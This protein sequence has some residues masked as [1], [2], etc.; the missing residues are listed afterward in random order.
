MARTKIYPQIYVFSQDWIPGMVCVGYTTQ[1]D[2]ND[3][4]KQEVANK[5]MPAGYSKPYNLEYHCDAYDDNG[6]IFM[7]H[8]VHEYL[9][10][11]GIYRELDYDGKKTEWFRATVEEVKSAIVAVKTGKTVSSKTTQSFAMRPEQQAAVKMASEYFRNSDATTPH[12][13]FNAKMRFGKCFTTYQL[14]K[15]MGWT[16][17]LVLT[18]KPAVL[19]SW[20]EDLESHVDFVGWQFVSRDGKSFEDCDITKPIVAF[21][22]LQDFN[23]TTDD[24]DIKEH[25]K[26]AYNVDWDCIVFDEYHYGAWRKKTKELVDDVDEITDEFDES[27]TALKTKYFLYLSGTPFRALASNEFSAEQIYNWTYSDEQKAKLEF[28]NL[29]AFPDYVSKPGEKNPYAIMPQMI[30]MTYQLPEDIAQVAMKTGYDEF[31][32]NEFFKASF[33][34]IDEVDEDGNTITKHVAKFKY[35]SEVS[36]FLKFITADD[37]KQGYVEKKIAGKDAPLMPYEDKKKIEMTI[38]GKKEE[39]VISEGTQHTI[40][41]LPDVA[42]CYAMFDMLKKEPYFDSYKK[43]LC[44]GPACGNGAEAKIP[45]DNA[46]TRNPI[47]TKTITL[48]C[49]KLMTGVT[50]KPWSSIF[51]LQSCQSPETYFQSAFRVQSPWTIHDDADTYNLKDYCFIFDFAPN[52][53]LSQIAKYCDKQNIHNTKTPEEAVNDFIKFLPVLAY[54]GIVMEQVDAA[55]LL[56][57]AM[58]NT[59]ATLLAKGWNSA[60]LVNLD[61]DVLEGVLKDDKALEIIGS[62]ENWRNPTDNIS[63]IV[64]VTKE[65]G[66]LKTKERKEGLSEE[67]KKKK[68]VLEKKKKEVDENKKKMREKLQAFATRIPLFIYLADDRR[69]ATLQ[70]IIY[71]LEPELFKK[72]TG[73]SHEDFEYLKDM[74]VI[75]ASLMNKAVYDF[76]KYEQDS[77]SY[78]G[79]EKHLGE[80]VGGYDTIVSE[81]EFKEL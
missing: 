70:N 6:Q 76:R 79:I 31:D 67:E 50:I 62:I 53:A 64:N 5:L 77:L 81:S 69:A 71:P 80:D 11:N 13:L 54:G 61:V 68:T 17:I 46:M 20:Q 4:I 2:V 7:D 24:G 10:K 75:N 16:R 3:R 23:G 1:K 40:W 27:K 12:F 55:G 60:L 21:G 72:V 25:N 9:E 30:M 63:T 56:D 44:A 48:S 39:I 78:T 18:Y 29:S 73:I 36:K 14:A 37:I 59:T 42:S 41:L 8:K 45:V 65:L 51:M 52:R 66:E 19:S 28:P 35:E 33:E 22:S 57:I 34:D 74:G 15:E 58:G 49:G 26:W 32:L 47:K 43:V 38:N